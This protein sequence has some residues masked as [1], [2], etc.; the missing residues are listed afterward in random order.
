MA[1]IIG[2]NDL[3]AT[4]LAYEVQRGA[5]FV[6]YEYCISVIFMTFKR[7]SEIYFIRPEDNALVK[8]LQFSLISFLFGWW[9]FPWG[10]IYTPGALITNFRGGKDVTQD[11]LAYFD[12][13]PG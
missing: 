5:K 2:I 12:Q 10:L 9:G 1:K 13:A 8:G 11:V 3:D 7:S 4:Q 6:M